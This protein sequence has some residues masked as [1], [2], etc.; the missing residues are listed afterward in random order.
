MNPTKG[1]TR[2]FSDLAGPLSLDSL[3][4]TFKI[5]LEIDTELDAS[6]EGEGGVKGA[7]RA[8][9]GP[10]LPHFGRAAAHRASVCASD[11]GAAARVAWSEWFSTPRK[12][13]GG[14]A[15]APL[16]S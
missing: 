11:A 8:I 2:Q 9:E 3:Q 12:I 10:T 16:V 1:I 5:Q 15:S 14:H 7:S 6:T 4:R 13:S